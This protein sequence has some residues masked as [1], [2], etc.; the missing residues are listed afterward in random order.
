MIVFAAL[1]KVGEG[2]DVMKVTRY[3]AFS[4]AIA[5]VAGLT[6]SAGTPVLA[7]GTPAPGWPQPRYNAAGNLGY[8]PA[9]TQL[10]TGNV[11]RLSPTPSHRWTGRSPLRHRWWRTGW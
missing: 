10:G 1:G 4:A 5:A 7:S 9:E 8:N 2:G 3:R 6:L 11:G